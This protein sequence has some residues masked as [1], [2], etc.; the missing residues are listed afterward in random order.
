MTTTAAERPSY[1]VQRPLWVLILLQSDA[2]I[3]GLFLRKSPGEWIHPPWF[4]LYAAAL[5]SCAAVVWLWVAAWIERHTGPFR[6]YLDPARPDVAIWAAFVGL[7]FIASLPAAWDNLRRRRTWNEI[8]PT[9]FVGW[10]RTLRF[11]AFGAAPGERARSRFWARAALWREPLLG[12]SVAGLCTLIS[13]AL[14]LYL[15]V[16]VGLLR[17]Q[18][19]RILKRERRQRLALGDA[20]S[21]RARVQRLLEEI[22]QRNRAPR[23]RKAARRVRRRQDT[24]RRKDR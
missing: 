10:P 4:P 18:S 12:F 20:F 2:R 24:R 13:P 15:A 14:G 3:A 23:A 6:S 7:V 11:Q 17:I 21:E 8:R 19:K 22:D 1:C 16:N 5:V 9:T